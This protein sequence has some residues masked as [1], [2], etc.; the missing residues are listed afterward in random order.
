M[1]QGLYAWDRY[2]CPRTARLD[3]SDGGFLSDPNTDY[4]RIA[5][6][7]LVLFSEVSGQY[8]LVLLGEPGIG[9]T[10]TLRLEFQRQKAAAGNDGH[11]I[12]D[13]ESVPVAFFNC[14]RRHPWEGA[15]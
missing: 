10:Q 9:K 1:G 5:N 14:E 11:F 15:I 4:G 8:C 6:S 7:E 2:W 3:L 12:T 13:G